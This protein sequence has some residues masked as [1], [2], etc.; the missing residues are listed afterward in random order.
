[1]EGYKIKVKELIERLGRFNPDWEI[2]LN[3]SIN[4]GD[5][6]V[7]K[8]YVDTGD[9]QNY[10]IDI[11]NYEYEDDETGAIKKSKDIVLYFYVW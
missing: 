4:T 6:K 5:C 8:G 2:V 1:M 11:S 3:C 7:W 9:T 10:E